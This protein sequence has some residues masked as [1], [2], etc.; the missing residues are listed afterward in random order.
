M[1]INSAYFLPVVDGAASNIMATNG[2]EEL[3]WNPVNHV[4]GEAVQFVY[5]VDST[6]SSLTPGAIPIDD[7]IPQVTE[8]QQVVSLAITPTDAANI[9]V[10][11]YDGS[12]DASTVPKYITFALFKNGA[13]NAIYTSSLY[14][15][16]SA[17]GQ[18]NNI[19]YYYAVA[20]GTTAQ[21]YTIRVGSTT[22][23]YKN[24]IFSGNRYNGTMRSVF[25]INEIVP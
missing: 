9:L 22:T 17:G 3:Y 7:S 18:R 5:N 10:F 6:V 1:T 21:T 14:I 2:A 15:E 11:K 12:Y 25:T 16:N 8:G 23:V 19:M 13:A 4:V 24:R 20:G